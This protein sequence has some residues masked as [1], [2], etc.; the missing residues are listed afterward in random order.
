MEKVEQTIC[1]YMIWLLVKISISYFAWK[2]LNKNPTSC[3]PQVSRTGGDALMAKC[4]PDPGTAQH[5]VGESSISCSIQPCVV[6]TF[7]G[8]CRQRG[9]EETVTCGIFAPCSPHS[10]EPS[11]GSFLSY[12]PWRNVAIFSFIYSPSQFFLSMQVQEVLGNGL[13]AFSALEVCDSDMYLIVILYLFRKQKNRFVSLLHKWDSEIPLK[14]PYM[15]SSLLISV[16]THTT[17]RCWGGQLQQ[18]AT[19]IKG[20]HWK[21]FKWSY[22]VNK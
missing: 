19:F 2:A 12:S 16:Q 14:F 3:L 11:P 22:A 1:I 10:S 4:S 6:D 18:Y 7:L 5:R 9:K 15:C 13:C 20:K 17:I 8:C 21:I